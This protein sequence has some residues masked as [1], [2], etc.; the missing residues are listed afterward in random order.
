MRSL[1]NIA[2]ITAAFTLAACSDDTKKEAEK[3]DAEVEAAAEE[4]QTE[5]ADMMEKAEEMA[6]AAMEK[7]GE[8]MEGVTLDTSSLENFKASLADMKASLSA[9]QASQLSSAL[10]KLAKDAAGDKN[11]MMSAAKGMAAG[12]STEDILYDNMKDKL[13]GMSF[14]DVLKLAS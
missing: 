8:M 4:V 1:L 11:S 5:T 10:S 3:A 2:A 13:D 12:K 7:A 6:D 9:E 14:E